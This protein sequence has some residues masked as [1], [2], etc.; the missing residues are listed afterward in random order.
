MKYIPCT[1]ETLSDHGDD[2][3]IIHVPAADAN[4]AAALFSQLLSGIR[5]RIV[6]QDRKTEFTLTSDTAAYNGRSVNITGAYL[7]CLEKLF[8]A[9]IRPGISHLDWD[10]SDTNGNLCITVRITP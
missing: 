9:D 2:C 6:F 10:F 4:D 5:K 1:I 7:E 3:R 8:S